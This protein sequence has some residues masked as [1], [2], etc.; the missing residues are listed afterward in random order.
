M[1]KVKKRILSFIVSLA[2]VLTTIMPNMA[3]VAQASQIDRPSDFEG[4]VYVTYSDDGEFAPGKTDSGVMAYVPVSLETLAAARVS[5]DFDY[6]ANG[7][8]T[9]EL[10]VY[11]L[12][13]YMRDNYSYGSSDDMTVTGS[14][15]SIYYSSGLWCDENGNNW[16]ENTNYYYNG[17]YPYA[18]EGWGATADQITLHDGDFIDAAHFSDWGFFS[19]TRAPFQY[20]ATTAFLDDYNA[21]EVKKSTVDGPAGYAT[22]SFSGTAGES[23]DLVLIHTSPDNETFSSTTYG[24]YN[25]VTIYYGKE[26][27]TAEGSVVSGTNA[28][29]TVGLTE[30]IFPEEGDYWIWTKGQPGEN[31]SGIVNG[32]AVAKVHVEPGSIQPAEPINVNVSISNA[33]Q[34]VMAQKSVSVT[35]NNRD[36]TLDVFEA[37]YAAHEASFEGGAAAGFATTEGSYGTT[38]TKLWGVDGIPMYAINHDAG[39]YGTT[40]A[41]DDL[42]YAYNLKDAANYSDSYSKFD[43]DTYEVEATTGLSVEL[44]R[45]FSDPDNEWAMTQQ[46]FAGATLAVLGTDLSAVDAS[47]YSFKDN[48]GGSYT[49]T[50]DEAGE[51]FL[52]ANCDNPILVPA[53]AKV[54]V[55]EAPEPVN[56]PPALA[57]GVEATAEATV[58]AGEAY[59]LDLTKIFTDADGDELT[60]TVKVGDA[61]AVAAD[62]A[63]SYTP[64]EA[65]TYTLLF[66]ANDGKAEP[67]DSY[68]VVLTVE[69]PAAGSDPTLFWDYTVD[70]NG[71]YAWSTSWNYVQTVS[72]TGVSVE[73]YE[74]DGN[75]CN[76]I[77]VPS[78]YKDASFT[79]NTT[80]YAR[81]GGIRVNGTDAGTSSSSTQLELTDGVASITIQPYAGSRV[82]TTKTFS[83]SIRGGGV[84]SEY[85]IS[86]VNGE[87]YEIAAAEGYTQPVGSN[88]TY[89]V[90]VNILDGYKKGQNF[91]ALSNGSEIT[92]DEND[93]YIISGIKENKEITVQDVVSASTVFYWDVILPADP[94]GYTVTAVEEYESPVEET[95][96]YKFTVAISEGY[97]KNESFA[98]KANGTALIPDE[99]GVYTIENITAH[100]TV[101]VE[102]V[103]DIYDVTLESGTGY[104]VAAAE[105]YTSPVYSGKEYKFTVAIAEGYKQGA[106]F[107]VKVNGTAVTPDAEGVYTI[108]NIREAKTVTVEDV[109]TEDTVLEYRITLP[110]AAGY[111][112]LPEEG[113]SSPVIEG[114]DFKFSVTVN[115]GYLK[116]SS[117]AVK[118]NGEALT[119][120]EDGVYTIPAINDHQTITVEG[121]IQA[122]AV[123]APE[124]STIC[125]GNLSGSFKYTWYDPA[126]VKTAEDGTVTA[127]FAPVS[128]TSFYRVQ[129]PKGVTYWDFQSMAAGKAYTVTE[130]DLH[131]DDDTFN[132]DTYYHDF[133]YNYLD[134][135]D[136]YLNINE[137]NYLSMEAGATRELDVFRNWQAIESFTNSKIAIPDAHYEVV[138]INGN[139]SD[140]VTVTPDA[141]NSCLAD[142]TAV[143][144]SG[145]AI[146]KVT[147]DA[148]IHK[149]GYASGYG[150]G[151]SDP[152]RFS[153]I[154]PECTGVIVVTVG[155]D[156]SAIDMG[157]KINVGTHAGK[158]AGDY[159]D[160]EHDLLYY[161][162]DKGAEFTFT[163]ESGATVSIARSTVD[164]KTLTYSGFTTEGVITDDKGNVMVTGLTSGRHIVKVEKDGVANY[165]VLSARYV[166]LEYLDTEGNSAGK[167]YQFKPGDK[168]TLRLH[169]VNSPQE[170][171]ATCYNNSFSV[172]YYGE[173][174]PTTRLPYTNAG[175]H[176]YGQ[177]NFTSMNQDITVSIPEDWEKDTYSITNGAIAMAGFS[178][179]AAGGHRGKV[180]YRNASG[181]ATGSSGT[182]VLAKLPDIVLN[183]YQPHEHELVKT[184]AKDATCTE[185]GNSEYYTCSVCGKYFSDAEGTAEIE[186]DSWIIPAGH[187]LAKTEAVAATCTAAGNSEYYTC[188]ECGKY[189]SDAEGKNEIE[190]D[191]W[192]IPASGHELVKVEAKGATSTADGNIE[193]WTCQKCGKLFSDSE[194]TT[195]ITEADTIIKAVPLVK[196]NDET[197]TPA[198]GQMFNNFTYGYHSETEFKVVVEA[199]EDASV[200]VNGSDTRETTFAVRT[201]LIQVT[202]QRGTDGPTMLYIW[203]NDTGHV[204]AK[205]EAV[206]ATCTAA[207]NSEYWTCSECGKYFSDAEGKNEIEK[208]SW[209][210]D[211]SGH[212]LVKT[213]AKEAA[214]TADGNIEYWTCQKCGKVFSD[215]EG[216]KEIAIA[217]TVIPAVPVVKVNDET[218]TPAAGQTINSFTYGYHAETEFKVVVEAPEDANVFVNGSSTRETTF[219]VPTA[220]IQ[221]II[222]RGTAG[223][224]MFY[225][226]TKDTGHMLAKTEAVAASCTAAGNKEYYTCSECGKYFSDEAGTTEI[227]KN[228]WIIDASGH[229]LVKTEAKEATSTA[230]GN[231]EYWTCQKC[232]KVFSDAEGTKEIAI[233]DTVIPA[234]PV[235][236]VN[237]ETYTPA[238]GQ[239]FNNFTYGYH[240]ETEFK[241]VVE[242]PEDASVNVNGSDTR[243]TTFAVRTALIQVTI[244]RG[245]DGP[246]MF[247]IWPNDTGHVLAKTEAATA[248]CTAA[249][250]SEYWTCSECGKYFS[251]AEGT[252]EIE[253]DNWII[254]AKGHSWDA[255]AVTKEP[256]YTEPGTRTYTCTV[257]GETKTE[258]IEALLPDFEVKHALNLQDEILVNFYYIGVDAE[259]AANSSVKFT[260][261]GEEIVVTGGK[262]RTVGDKPAVVYTF[263]T[264]A[265]KMTMP[266]TAEF[267]IDGKVVETHEYT[268]KQ[269]CDD[270]VAKADIEPKFKTLLEAT[271]NYGGY[272]Q[273][274]FNY[275]TDKPANADIESTLPDLK[276][277][278]IEAPVFDKDAVIAGVKASGLTYEGAT[279]ALEA[280]TILKLYFK[281]DGITQ[282]AAL[283][284]PVKVNGADAQLVKNGKYVCLTIT[285]IKAKALGEAYDITVGD[286][287]FSYSPLNYIK[288]Q[289]DGTDTNLKNV[290]TAMY[291]YYK[292][293]EDYFSAS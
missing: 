199:P 242:A 263:A 238:A 293:A 3:V 41:A 251:D 272:S 147:Y 164:T 2:M 19:E 185:P 9:A 270:Q 287:S 246:T 54:T 146:I 240:S 44:S 117:F 155:E 60:F 121:V 245:T 279:L 166:E 209:I 83:F 252:T 215:A 64:E 187:E 274:N 205:T 282:D 202:I 235:V 94:V 211:A 232:G 221:V 159:I 8:G 190:K 112:V 144:G 278:D 133:V 97:A 217:D 234:V 56:N 113:Y 22:H 248:T 118:A 21:G 87:G 154:W 284:V 92:A 90:V 128:G 138:D 231:I 285:G 26:I 172:A 70:G 268:V 176:G 123:T 207:G 148:M 244:Q 127:Y 291:Y 28:S 169:N 111:S 289:L 275:N 236:K 178:G 32:P 11:T 292:A 6:D 189:F 239:M 15:G 259:A 269:Y 243:E 152:T 177:Y 110:E 75:T 261:E 29:G 57:E 115:D 149:Q 219:A 13:K 12:F 38:I 49:V 14:N 271:L 262:T 1:E 182:G 76:I 43:K 62:A 137:R 95:K 40:V 229:D 63:Y 17:M 153:A 197:Y 16:D 277:S 81:T 33:G 195:E 108:S 18:E 173:D 34:V 72:A 109:V 192:I 31:T 119:P 42:V 116:N 223:P 74:W 255:G 131:M 210:I 103:Q 37:L 163:P 66:K 50:F 27:G 183:I 134:L 191:S 47:R 226:S 216:T 283:K 106:D 135:A 168:L 125:A 157:M 36:G 98:V 77:L 130:T 124:G 45:F 193:Y 201:A 257:C 145:M 258:E 89:G 132:S 220:M 93:V 46:A 91:K 5:D 96:D 281:A 67:E 237:D 165:Q 256:T 250:N 59:S 48:G 264:A 24:L 288:T 222:Q 88:G 86:F 174:A 213:E 198:A 170:K 7:D 254:E 65:G 143:S 68:T 141:H 247:Y 79:I 69:K 206:A 85:Y 184:E 82:G 140:L 227:E 100:Q 241:V 142:I 203:P 224:T 61:E 84:D 51:Y 55:A 104:T 260:F 156:G 181:M 20:F 35:D 253:K 23:V 212:D 225:I 267:S 150:A 122:A 73:S 204:L 208:D 276:P 30:I 186:A 151:G 114:K 167:E 162:D 175:D 286:Y 136:V 102:G 179:C 188:S 180:T 233:A 101:T 218:Y 228:S 196:V 161:F 25:D 71:W 265:K 99:D 10:T 139:P 107:A 290:L 266:I 78:T 171:L 4:T 126:E 52:T 249:G 120:G 39:G 214:S 160:A 105:G 80:S 230:D 273:V 200:N 194:G 129:N 280:A 58:T 53:V 158:V